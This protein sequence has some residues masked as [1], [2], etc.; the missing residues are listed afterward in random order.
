MFVECY[1]FFIDIALLPIAR[2]Y[3]AVTPCYCIPTAGNLNEISFIISNFFLMAY[4][5]INY[6]CFAGS[7]AKSPGEEGIES[8]GHFFFGYIMHEI[9]VHAVLELL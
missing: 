6:S 8:M 9:N 4:A 2:V 3:F 1:W 5:L 7:F